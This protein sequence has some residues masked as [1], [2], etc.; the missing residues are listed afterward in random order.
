MEEYCSLKSI[1][2]VV[3]KKTLCCQFD[4][5]D[6][7]SWKLRLSFIEEKEIRPVILAYSQPS[8]RQLCHGE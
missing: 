8:H 4:M 6:G 7:R 1:S 5:S 3:R 2:K